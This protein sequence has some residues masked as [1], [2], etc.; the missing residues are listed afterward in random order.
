MRNAPPHALLN[1]IQ[2]GAVV[3]S[4][5]QEVILSTLARLLYGKGQ[6]TKQKYYRPLIKK[7]ATHYSARTTPYYLLPKLYLPIPIIIV[8]RLVALF[9]D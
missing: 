4:R 7:L 3:E 1:S 5:K 2:D 9:G 8:M 6:R